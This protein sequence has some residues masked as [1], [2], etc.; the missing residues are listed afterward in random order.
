MFRFLLLVI[1]LILLLDFRIGGAAVEQFQLPL[2]KTAIQSLAV[3][4]NDLQKQAPELARIEAAHT[5]LKEALGDGMPDDLR[6]GL[7][8]EETLLDTVTISYKT[9]EGLVNTTQ[10]FLDGIRGDNRESIMNAIDRADQS[11]VRFQDNIKLKNESRQEFK[12]RLGE[13]IDDL[14]G[15][16]P[17]EKPDYLAARDGL[18]PGNI[19][20]AIEYQKTILVRL[21][22]VIAALK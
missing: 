8:V 12:R 1:P 14:I 3:V 7:V 18:E 5:A 17:R 11:L 22:A 15:R 16:N 20:Q 4:R 2:I 13:T 21:R 9:I 10:S 19:D 6:Q